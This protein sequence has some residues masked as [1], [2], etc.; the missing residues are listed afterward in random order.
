MKNPS[1]IKRTQTGYQL[2]NLLA[3]NLPPRQSQALLLCAN[4]LTP[5]RSAELMGCSAKNVSQ[6]KNALFC[7][8]KANASAEL[9]M[10]AFQCGYL[11]FLSI[12]AAV[13]IG[14]GAPTVID[15]NH[16]AARLARSQRTQTARAQRKINCLF[17][18]A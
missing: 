7:K 6:L 16:F 5:S 12:M 10:R 15:H 4:G 2:G 11:R 14:I 17:E 1:E 18:I 9:I 8:L 13:L 3:E